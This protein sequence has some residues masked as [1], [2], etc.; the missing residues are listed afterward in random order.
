MTIERII[1]REPLDNPSE[2][3]IIEAFANAEREEFQVG[4]HDV[5]PPGYVNHYELKVWDPGNGDDIGEVFVQRTLNG[6]IQYLEVFESD[7]EL[8]DRY[9]KVVRHALG[10]GKP[11]FALCQS[12][13]EIDPNQSGIRHHGVIFHSSKGT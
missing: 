7:V 12:L 5:T 9:Q 4:T 13:N 3:E 1:F 11:F 10:P 6:P 8:V 2:Q